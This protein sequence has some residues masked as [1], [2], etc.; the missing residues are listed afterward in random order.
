MQPISQNNPNVYKGPSSSAEFNKLRNDIHYD[1]TQLFDVANQHEEDIKTNMDV[2]IREN[3]FMQNKIIELETLLSKVTKDVMYQKEG[4]NKQRL[5]KSF[6]S[7]EGLSDGDSNKQAYIN[8]MYGYLTIPASDTVSKISYKAEDDQ[9]VIPESL[10]VKVFESNNIQD[11]DQTTGML[12]YYEIDDDNTYLAFDRDKNSFWVHT[13]SFAEDSG[14]SEVYG[15]MH[16]TLPLD[17][18]NDVY[19]NTLVI[20]PFPEYSLRIRDIQVKGYG[21]QWYRLE[22]Y[23]TEKDENGEEVPVQIENSGKMTFSFPKSEITE[24][25]IFFAQPYWFANEGKREFVYGFQEIELEHRIVNKSEVEIVSEFSIEGTTKRFSMIEE[26]TV[27]AMTGSN[28]EINDL[29][30][31][32]LYYTKDLSNEFGF[33]NEIMAPIQ[34]VYVKTIIRGQGEIVPMLKK[35]N[36]DYTYKE[37]NEF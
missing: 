32:K 18:L 21:D 25:Q 26:P 34:K 4:Q 23:P 24:I 30:E 14:V 17:I 12:S 7:V 33:G 36:L 3:F 37:L 2:L 22:N 28:Q 10:G 31:H 9:V 13:S 11:I 5:I 20:N 29:V 16:I 35:I 8:T 1:L 15:I 19:S 6:Y 27:E